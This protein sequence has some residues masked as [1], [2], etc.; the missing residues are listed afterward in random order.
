M[1]KLFYFFTL[2]VFI[3]SINVYAGSGEGISSVGTLSSFNNTNTI[4]ITHGYTADWSPPHLHQLIDL[5][6]NIIF[7][8]LQWQMPLPIQTIAIYI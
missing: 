4:I 8:N 3:F 6:G 7:G 2:I 1:K 5:N